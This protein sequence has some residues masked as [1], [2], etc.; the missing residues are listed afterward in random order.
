M[1]VILKGEKPVMTLVEFKGLSM[2]Q[3]LDVV[4]T[5]V[6]IGERTTEN[7]S[8]ILVQL[9][10][11]YVEVFCNKGHEAIVSFHPFETVEE[12]NPYLEQITIE[13]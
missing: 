2:I 13:F 11:F 3:Q 6:E 10:S 12:L 8:V 7:F 1:A 5:G 9:E 4:L